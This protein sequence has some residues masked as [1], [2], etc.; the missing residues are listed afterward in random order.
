VSDEAMEQIAPG[1]RVRC[2]TAFGN[3]VEGT[4]CSGPRFDRTNAMDRHRSQCWLSISVQ[5]DG[6]DFPYN[7]P[8]EDVE[9]ISP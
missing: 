9:R 2:R 3:F 8:A 4:A 6:V 7:W 1:D 5:P